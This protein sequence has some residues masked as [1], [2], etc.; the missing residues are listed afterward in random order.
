MGTAAAVALAAC[1]PQPPAGTAAGGTSA[2]SSG[3][4][5]TSSAPAPATS[6][7]APAPAPT[8]PSAPTASATETL[9]PPPASDFVA[10]APE[11]VLAGL[12]GAAP[13]PTAAGLSRRLEALLSDP[14]LGGRVEYDITDV[15]TGEN[16][17]ARGAQTPVTPA[18]T[19][20]LLTAV[21]A[22]SVLGPQE[23]LATR[24]VPG[25]DDA[26]IVLVGGG[27]MLL[28]TGRGDP[29]K[30]VG[31]AGLTDLADG[32]A[33][34][35]RAAG[36]TRVVLRLDDT[37]FS[38]PRVSPAW[39]PADLTAG[40]VAPVAPLAVE[41]G[42]ASSGDPATAS[43]P[44]LAAATAFATLLGKRGITVTGVG[45]GRAPAGAPTVAEVLGAPVQDVVEHMLDQSDNTVAE[46]LAR[47]VAARGDQP[48]T[49]DGA[50]RAVI[51]AVAAL[52]VPTAG[53]RFTGGS[54]LGRGGVIAPRT[55]TAT[56]VLAASEKHPELRAT[57]TGLP[58]AG[59][60]GTLAERYSGA[61]QGGAVGVVRAKTG[62]LTGAS[63]LAGTVV[64]A[65]GRLLAFAVV[66]DRVTS[67][68]DA[69]D[70]LDSVAAALAGCGCS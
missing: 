35:L 67:T 50:G 64:D 27:D 15:E 18:S 42:R 53:A 3:P 8:V 25:A 22:L 68:G 59:V 20:K 7:S 65:D 21:A 33:D 13:V 66:A 51:D 57:L 61:G 44:A 52:G 40:F 60:T 29:T 47:L 31:H 32:T 23:R 45:R 1:V 6:S 9:G 54:G 43:D 26:T 56:I 48:P 16:L 63:S 46:V 12:T 10:P 37:L 11:P 55:L 24:V 5:T 49:F 69:R 62:T 58:V 36:R 30:V 19:T 17:L 41:S 34:A 14:G 39:S 70:A 28:A 2:A 38:G 4:A